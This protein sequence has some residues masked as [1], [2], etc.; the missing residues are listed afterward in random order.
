MKG[1]NLMP[2]EDKIDITDLQN[3]TLTVSDLRSIVTLLEH[4]TAHLILPDEVTVAL[5]RL[6]KLTDRKG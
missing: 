1:I 6:R 3:I 5:D 2:F 4:A